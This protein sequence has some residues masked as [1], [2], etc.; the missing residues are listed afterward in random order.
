[1]NKPSEE[2]L[3]ILNSILSRAFE[4]NYIWRSNC[5][6]DYEEIECCEK[7]QEDLFLVQNWVNGTI[8]NEKN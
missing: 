4:D 2:I 7:E 1:M 6:T 5:G 3:R 8:E